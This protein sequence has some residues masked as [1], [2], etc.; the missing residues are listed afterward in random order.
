MEFSGPAFYLHGTSNSC[1]VLITFFGKNKI[2]VN[3]QITD[4]QRRIL[5]LDVAIDGSEYILVNFY[6]ANTESEQ[7][8]VINDLSELMKKVNITQGKQ[9]V[10]AGDFNLFF[11][12]NLE[13]TGGKPFLKEKSIVRMVELKKEYGLSDIWRIRNSLEKPFTFRQNHSSGILNRRLDYIFISNKLQEFSNKAITLTA[14]KTDHLSVS[15]I[16]FN[17]NEIKPGPGPWR[18]NNFLITDKY[19]KEKL[20]NFIENLKEDLNSKISFDDQV[21]WEYMKFQIRKFTISYSKIRA[22]NNRRIKKDLENKL[23]DL[24]NDLNNCDQLQKYNEIKPEL[25]KIYEKFGEG[26]KV[27]SKCTWYEEGE[28]S[29]KFFLNLE[30]KIALQGQI[31]KLIIGN[32]GIMDQNKI[33]NELQLFYRNLFKSNC[34]KSYDDCKKFLDKIKTPVLT[35]EKANICGGDLVESQ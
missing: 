13:A 5:I 11:D 31:L 3:S 21:K 26:A 4:K 35:S 18:F 8:K 9:I 1:G 20:K 34:T 22:K 10:L 24:E 6:N 27:R 7:L 23:K 17:Y 25:E 29:K 33:Q 14:F 15:V 19:F 30:K 16:V 32:Q 28:K 12:S 2:C